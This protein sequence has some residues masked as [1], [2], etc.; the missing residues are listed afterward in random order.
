MRRIIGRGFSLI[1]LLMALSFLLLIIAMIMPSYNNF[2]RGQACATAAFEIEAQFRRIRQKSITQEK[3]I[4]CVLFSAPQTQYI[5]FDYD[6]S[7]LGKRQMFMKN[8]LGTRI[9]VPNEMVTGFSGLDFFPD[10]TI[11]C[12]MAAG[13]SPTITPFASTDADETSS[14]FVVRLSN[15]NSEYDVRL[16]RSGKIL[17]VKNI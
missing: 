15:F 2:R 11:N 5:Y 14:Y 8:Y 6:F 9:F 3:I 7:A 10:G 13:P 12:T 16:H 17:V 4:Q 1:E